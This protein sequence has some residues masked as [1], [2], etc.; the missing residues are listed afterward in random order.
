MTYKAMM[1]HT[2]AVCRAAATASARF[3]HE[4]AND[5][6]MGLLPMLRGKEV[7]PDED[8]FQVLIQHLEVMDP[9]ERAAAMTRA[10]AVLA[11]RQ[12]AATAVP[13]V[14]PP[15]V[16]TP[17]PTAVAADTTLPVGLPAED[18]PAQR[19]R[20]FELRDFAAPT[21]VPTPEDPPPPVEPVGRQHEPKLRDSAPPPPPGKAP[22][23]RPVTAMDPDGPAHSNVVPITD[24]L[25]ARKVFDPEGA[26]R[27]DLIKK[28]QE[29]QPGWEPPPRIRRTALVRMVSEK[30]GIA[31]AAAM[32]PGLQADEPVAEDPPEVPD[33][34]PTPLPV[35][36]QAMSVHE[37]LASVHR[38]PGIELDAEVVERA[39]QLHTHLRVCF[40]AEDTKAAIQSFYADQQCDQACVREGDGGS[41]GACP[42][43][44]TTPGRQGCWDR[45]WRDEP[46]DEAM[47]PE[48]VG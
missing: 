26:E 32:E 42:G 40:E 23:P 18:S 15:V 34:K 14:M 21:P 4:V 3:F 12:A 6:E 30:L 1:L 41:V 46:T 33:P 10:A 20:D 7:A 16:T 35:F 5:L 43:I 27:D 2:I 28:M 24:A 44:L 38:P 11:E 39:R 25:D 8:A 31:I 37:R 17:P 29:L 19:Q 9:A 45:W 13:P 48:V 36:Q 47:P 22:G